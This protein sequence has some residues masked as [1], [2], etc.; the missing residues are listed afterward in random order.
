MPPSRS[1]RTRS[2]CPRSRSR[3]ARD[4][5]YVQSLG[6]SLIASSIFVVASSTLLASCAS[7]PSSISAS[8]LF[9]LSMVLSA[10]SAAV[11]SL[12]SP[13][14]ISPP[15]VLPRLLAAQS[16][17]KSRTN[18]SSPAS[19]PATATDIARRMHA[20][21][22]RRFIGRLPART[23][24]TSTRP[25]SDRLNV[26]RSSWPLARRAM[27]DGC[28]EEAQAL[29]RP[30]PI[31]DRDPGDAQLPSTTVGQPHEHLDQAG[32]IRW[33]RGIGSR[34]TCRARRRRSPRCRRASATGR[35]SSRSCRSP[36]PPS[37]PSAPGRPRGPACPRAGSRRLGAARAVAGRAGSAPCWR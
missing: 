25:S 19:Q 14:P 4:V 12:P 22:A 2:N 7:R 9:T 24:P 16:S 30:I 15:K 20:R 29:A 34:P 27:E 5:R 8:A 37:M 26:F 21:P 36:T 1:R 32:P 13:T 33:R 18:A 23:A 31:V 11:T 28:R 35:G 3:T 10:P 17:M 6:L